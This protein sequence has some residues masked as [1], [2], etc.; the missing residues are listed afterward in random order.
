MDEILISIIDNMEKRIV[1]ADE[2]HTIRYINKSAK[3]NFE[4]KNLTDLLNKSV[5]EFHNLETNEKIKMAVR[6]LKANSSLNKVTIG[7]TDIFAVRVNNI[8]RGYYEIF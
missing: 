7:T 2:Y 1:F 4:R 8:F 6:M 5:L 3:E